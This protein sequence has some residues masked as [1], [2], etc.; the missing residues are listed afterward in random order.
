MIDKPGVYEISFEEYLADPCPEPSLSRSAISTLLSKSPRHAFHEHPRL[1]PAPVIEKEA[2]HFD[3]GTAAHSLFLQGTDVAEIITADD[4]KT[5]ASREARD[6]ARKNGKVPL[7]TI[8]AAAVMDMV[9]AAHTQLVDSE[10]GLLIKKQH[11]ELTYI[12]KEEDSWCRIRPD[13]INKGQGIILDYKTTG[14]SAKPETFFRGVIANGLD[15]QEAFYKRG[16][17]AIDGIDYRFIFMVQEVTPPYLCSFI[18]LN[19]EFQNMG[20]QKV[21]K[22]IRK[23][24]DCISSG[25]WPGYPTRVATI[26]APAYA[27]AAWEFQSMMMEETSGNIPF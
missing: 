22:G 9:E 24:K 12:W 27:V 8:Q 13:F 14:I 6:N 17:K 21:E 5:K 26:E 18:D 10:L 2:A 19:P 25:I 11:T 1:N 3:I 16:V 15:I 20:N 4:W 23:W 7:L